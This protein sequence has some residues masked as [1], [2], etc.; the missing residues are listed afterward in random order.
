MSIRIKFS[1]SE[2]RD[3]AARI[4][5]IERYKIVNVSA[6]CGGKTYFALIEVGKN[7]YSRTFTVWELVDAMPLRQENV[8]ADL[9][10][11]PQGLLQSLSFL[12]LSML[13]DLAGLKKAY[14]KLSLELHP[15]R[16]GNPE[17]F[18]QLKTSYDL[19]LQYL[20]FGINR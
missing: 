17:D 10:L 4:L 6:T 15:D 2:L 14:R 19:V 12:G 13:P 11:C 18:C 8:S 3:R 16:G 7:Q 1:Q 5:S 9:N 20:Q